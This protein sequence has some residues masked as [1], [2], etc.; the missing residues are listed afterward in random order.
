MKQKPKNGAGLHV[1]VAT[2]GKPKDYE[3]TKGLSPKTV[4]NIKSNKK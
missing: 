4:P 2:G 1:F 3:G